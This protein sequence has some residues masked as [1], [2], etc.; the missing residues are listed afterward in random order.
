ML[1]VVTGP[2]DP[3]DGENTVEV[4]RVSTISGGKY[5]FYEEYWAGK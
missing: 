2:P 5:L 1:C 4:D 3:H